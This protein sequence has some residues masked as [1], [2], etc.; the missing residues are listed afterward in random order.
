[1]DAEERLVVAL[2]KHAHKKLYEEG[3]VYVML[4]EIEEIVREQGA[5]ETIARH[6]LRRLENEGLLATDDGHFYR[7]DVA[8]AVLY[9]DRY[10]RREL[11]R[12]NALR[13]EVLRLRR[14]PSSA[15]SASSTTTRTASASSTRPTRKPSPPRE[16]SKPGGSSSSASSSAASSP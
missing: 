2:A 15:T 7:G 14:N 10:D 3:D 4:G 1:M 6:V 9:E 8:L 11:W 13:R 12:A 5:P 16:R